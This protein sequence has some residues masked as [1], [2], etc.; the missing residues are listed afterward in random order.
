MSDI[1]YSLE[2]ENG[3]KAILGEVKDYEVLHMV[4]F[5]AEDELLKRLRKGTDMIGCRN[6][7][8]TA[9]CLL[10]VAAYR[11][12]YG[13]VERFDA[14]NLAMTFRDDSD[15]LI[16]MAYR[17]IAPWCAGDFSFRGVRG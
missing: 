7:F 2:I 9:A 13:Q 12:I 4:C 1:S 10:S 15:T 16:Q 5:A 6:T 17:M 3:T 8:V 11:R 14:G